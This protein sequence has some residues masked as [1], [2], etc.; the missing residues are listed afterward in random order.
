MTKPTAN[1]LIP[2]A[3][4]LR[5][6]G[7]KK[8]LVFLLLFATLFLT[9]SPAHAQTS[10]VFGL[11]P[12]RVFAPPGTEFNITVGVESGVAEVSSEAARLR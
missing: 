7:F 1:R 5:R 4:K 2:I 12:N 3:C 10:P 11:A 9:T 8:T 6:L